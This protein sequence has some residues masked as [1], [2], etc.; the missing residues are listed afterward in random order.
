MIGTKD[1]K[2]NNIITVSSK[3]YENGSLGQEEQ[4]VLTLEDVTPKLDKWWFQYPHLLKLN[5]LL[6]CASL[7]QVTLGYDGSMMGNLQTLPSWSA[8]FNKPHGQILSTMT[9]GITIGAMAVTPFLTASGDRMKRKHVLAGAILLTI[10]GAA[11]QSASVNFGMFLAA[12]MILGFGSGGMQVSAAPLLAET[13]Y[14]SQR[15]ILTSMLQ[16]AFPVGSFM[17][18]LFTW[19]P[20]QSSMKYNN[21][22]WR[23]PS[24]LQAVVPLIQLVL[25]YFCPESP[26]W[27]I[28]HGKEDE[29]F[30]ILTKYHAG[31]DR[32][33]ELVKFE[34][35]EISAAISREKIG[36]K[37][38]WLT[39][40]SS[41]ANMHRLFITLALPS[42]LQLCG[43]SLIA[44]YFSIV[45][46]DIGITEPSDKLKI[47]IGLTLFGGVCALV[48][49][50][51][52][53]KWRRK[54]VM[55]VSLGGMCIIF[56][57]WIVLADINEKTQFKNKALGR[58]I[59]AL[60][61]FDMGFYHA[62]SPIGNTYVME[63]VPYTLRGKASILYS[64]ASQ[65]WIFFNNYVNNLGMDSIGWKYYIVYCILLFTH[66]VVIQFTFPETRGLGL[67][68][69]A[70][71]FGEDI[72]DLMFKA[73]Q[74]IVEPESP[75][76]RKAE[77]EHIEDTK[78][79]TSET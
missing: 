39:W 27:L 69:V 4:R 73:Q 76:K 56:I 8:Y 23:L 5:V 45:L 36:K 50:I 12:R 58:G 18:A 47:N 22:S 49:A 43:S 54:V 66:M 42:I 11:L 2:E 7:A 6:G 75:T 38:S 55:Q 19:G 44:Y 3:G 16:A 24:L 20:Y 25:V 52:S 9:N 78:S 77:V 30:E 64:L 70:K 17:A 63:I 14:P 29:A 61:Y 60:L 15:P 37:V 35:A 72:S 48:F 65:V 67:E 40:F 13:A 62:F 46:Q 32:N 53:A 68:E 79:K 34:M 21:W 33:S 10:L 74:A 28:A 26:R 31:G 59:I 57:I 71:I 41:K 51:Y 1:I